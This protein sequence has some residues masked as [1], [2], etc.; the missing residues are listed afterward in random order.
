MD[1]LGLANSKENRRILDREIRRIL[2]KEEAS[3]PEVWNDLKERIH[4]P[5]QK[6][7]LVLELKAK[8]IN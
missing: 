4:D 8:A 7:K 2:K 3:C 1:E 5:D 6:K